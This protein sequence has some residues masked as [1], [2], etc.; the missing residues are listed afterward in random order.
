MH[1]GYDDWSTHAAILLV[2]KGALALSCDS[3]EK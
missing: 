1:S 3:L 2:D